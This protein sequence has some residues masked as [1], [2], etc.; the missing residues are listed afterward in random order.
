MPLASSLRGANRIVL[1]H[2]LRFST[3]LSMNTF[4]SV[5]SFITSSE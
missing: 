5:S 3:P 2:A 4:G 1:V